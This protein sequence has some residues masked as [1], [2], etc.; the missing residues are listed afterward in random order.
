MIFRTQPTKKWNN[1][2]FALIEAFQ[3]LDDEICKQCGN[4]VWL[5]RSN[6]N[7]FEFQVKEEI[8]YATQKLERVK[9]VKKKPKE[10]A[11]KEDRANFGKFY[12]TIPKLYPFE[13]EMPTRKDYIAEKERLVN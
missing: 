13:D 3:I 12:Y 7:K 8:C 1:W 9:D 11:S 2:D 10:R 4:P 5:C 6:S